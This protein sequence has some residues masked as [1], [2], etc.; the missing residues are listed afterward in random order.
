M[1]GGR[2]MDLGWLRA[3]AVGVENLTQLKDGC[4]LTLS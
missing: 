2:F 4:W 3:V 1:A